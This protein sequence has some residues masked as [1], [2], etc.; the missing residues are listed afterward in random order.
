MNMIIVNKLR[1]GLSRGDFRDKLGAISTG[2]PE[3]EGTM[4][5]RIALIFRITALVLAGAVLL[6]CLSAVIYCG[7]IGATTFEEG[8]D[9]IWSLLFRENDVFYRKSYTVSD[10][11]AMDKREVAVAKVGDRELT[12]GQ[13]QVCYW[14]NVYD[15]LNQY[16]SYG[17]YIGLDYTQPLDEQTCSQ[18]DGTWQ[19]YFLQDTISSWYTYQAM[20]LMA[21]EQGLELSAQ[22]QENLDGLKET[23][24]QSANEGGFA[25]LDAMVQADMGA[26]CT[27][28]DY[29]AY[30]STYYW[31][32]QYYS[33][34]L[35][36]Q[37]ITEE[38]LEAYFAEHESE[39]AEDK[40][41][42]TSGDLVDIRQFLIQPEDGV[43]DEDG[44]TTYSEEAWEECQE[45]AQKLLDQWL[46]G[47]KTES[48]F[49][50]LANDY[51]G[52][53]DDQT[54]GLIEDIYQG[55]LTEELNTWCFAGERQAGDYGLVKTKYGY[56]IVYFVTSE[57]E[58]HRKCSE[59]VT[60]ELAQDILEEARNRYVLEVEYKKIVLAEVD[61]S[62]Q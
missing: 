32:Y 48:S 22:L 38:M 4:K 35:S 6:A 53:D 21:K 41:T 9:A 46:A 17:A 54:G 43:E 14:M 28:E 42:K 52:D 55:Y 3:K 10:K 25:S 45:Q 34:C 62:E 12:N 60:A 20:A 56:H 40:V 8:K 24:T 19:Q 15:Y 58:W 49:A 57:A 44:N 59:G 27:F 36:G 13:L 39:L 30:M 50:E 29:Y 26:G 47:E 37:E 51:S 2:L 61:L 7:V 5:H 33:D 18:I 11:N 23:M 1:Q 16:G 31:G